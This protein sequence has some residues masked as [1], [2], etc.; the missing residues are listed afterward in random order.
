MKRSLAAATLAGALML[1]PMA[2]AAAT[3]EPVAPVSGCT[4][5]PPGTGGCSW[6]HE[7]GNLLTAGSSA[8]SSGSKS[9]K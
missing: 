4:T 1:A 9:A 7:L 5:I 2:T 3:A 6:F 8:L